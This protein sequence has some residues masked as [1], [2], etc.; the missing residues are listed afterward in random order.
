M[1][2]AGTGSFGS[3]KVT[4]FRFEGSDVDQLE[5]FVSRSMQLSLTISDG[6]LYLSDSIN[7]LSLKAVQLHFEK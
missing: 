3:A 7:H 6:E 1:G 5:S 4:V 2:K